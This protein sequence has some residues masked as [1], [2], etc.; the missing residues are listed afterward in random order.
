MIHAYHLVNATA[1]AVAD[2]AGISRDGLVEMVLP[3]GVLKWHDD[4]RGEISSRIIQA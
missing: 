2:E 3:G 1:Q 4:G